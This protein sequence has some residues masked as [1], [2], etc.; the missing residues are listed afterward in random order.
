MGCRQAN[1]P[2]PAPHYANALVGP[3][4][5]DSLACGM[6]TLIIRP[7]TTRQW[8]NSQARK[9][10]VIAQCGSLTG[11]PISLLRLTRI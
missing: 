11:N 4:S 9:P 1:L 3:K 6:E 8:L 2:R 10:P 5:R 7:N